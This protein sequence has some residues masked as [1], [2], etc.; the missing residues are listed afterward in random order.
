MLTRPATSGGETPPEKNAPGCW[1]GE[2]E[3]GKG[4]KAVVVVVGGAAKFV[5]VDTAGAEGV[6]VMSPANNRLERGK[7]EEDDIADGQGDG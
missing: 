4:T 2:D 3:V 7:E 6:T 5:P 1:G